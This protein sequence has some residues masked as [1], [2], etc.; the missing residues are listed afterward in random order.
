MTGCSVNGISWFILSC[1]DWWLWCS[2]TG[3]TCC[4]CLPL[5]NLD[6]SLMVMFYGLYQVNHPFK[7]PPFGRTCLE[8]FSKHLTSK[9]KTFTGSTLQT[10]PKDSPLGWSFEVVDQ[11]LFEL[12]IFGWRFP[13]QEVLVETKVKG[14]ILFPK[15]KGHKLLSC[16]TWRLVKCWAKKSVM[17]AQDSWSPSI[18]IGNPMV[19]FTHT[20]IMEIV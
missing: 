10:F 7:Q 5:K 6:L 19:V 14:G 15:I 17:E 13:P 12:M 9:S 3:I 20:P 18:E 4:F 1:P 8:L 16:G 2:F 11:T